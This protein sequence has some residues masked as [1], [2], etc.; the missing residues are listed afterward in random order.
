ML[1]AQNVHIET[2]QTG[3]NITPL[4][5]AICLQGLPLLNARQSRSSWLAARH[6]MKPQRAVLLMH[7]GSS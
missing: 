6:S 1:D 7:S 2:M 3:S 4:M 5:T